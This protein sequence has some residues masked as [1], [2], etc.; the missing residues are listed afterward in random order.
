[1]K[2][3]FM[4]LL[5]SLSLHQPAK[6]L[7]VVTLPFQVIGAIAQKDIYFFEFTRLD[8][9]FIRPTINTWGGA[10]PNPISTR[11]LAILLLPLA[12]LQ[13]DGSQVLTKE[14]LVAAAYTPDQAEVV[15]ADMNKFISAI[16]SG[17]IQTKEQTAS[18]LNKLSPVTKDYLS[19]AK[20]QQQ[21][22]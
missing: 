17:Q 22:H 3:V 19:R 12:L 20:A 18:L 15:L 4:I 7:D 16:Q 5:A 14:A 11:L 9:I 6:A 2:K 21:A 10:A 8:Y 13:E 1:M